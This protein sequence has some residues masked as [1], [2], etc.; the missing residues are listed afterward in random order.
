MPKLTGPLFSVEA[1][2]TL[3]NALTFKK[4]KEGQRVEKVPRPRDRK[5]V[6]Q[7]A[8]R[9]LFVEAVLYWHSLGM[10]QRD[11]AEVKGDALRITG[12]NYV[13]REYLRGRMIPGEIEAGT[14][15]KISISATPHSDYGLA[16][17]VTYKFSIPGSLESAKA[18]HKHSD[19]GSWLLLETKTGDDFFNGVEAARFDY[20]NNFAYL[21]VGF[22][23][24]SDDIYVAITDG[25]DEG[26]GINYVGMCDYYDGRKAVVAISMDDYSDKNR[27]CFL[28]CINACQARC[29]WITIGVIPGVSPEHG[30][31]GPIEW[32]A[33]Q[34]ELDEGYLE[35]S[36]HSRTHPHPPYGDP[37]SETGGCKGDIF[38]NVN[39][40]GIYKRSLEEY[41]PCWIEPF[42]EIDATIR[43]KLGLYKYLCDRST[44]IGVT[45]FASW[46]GGNGLYNRV[47]AYL[48][49]DFHM[50]HV[51]LNNAFDSVYNA[52][53]IY[54]M[55]GHPY[56][57]PGGG[58]CDDMSDPG[59][60]CQHLDYIKDRKDVWYAGFG[61]MYMYHYVVERGQVTVEVAA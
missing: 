37:D 6:A 38:D 57:P 59:E 58:A 51:Y 20:E 45:G 15:Y 40:P 5:S 52:G 23:G 8:Q 27:V 36:S 19:E 53:G 13:I 1:R 54:S 4:G 32:A 17:P 22:D 12:Y 7:V 29:V 14:V 3:G 47:G 30:E 35:V 28:N 49:W 34:T 10:S 24:A 56:R 26:Q 25:G 21:T 41:V 60:F 43:A 50:D 55:W 42:G 44:G 2:G 16:Y 46:D 11:Y 39:L 48:I 31:C 18:Y 61:A 9:D 33:L